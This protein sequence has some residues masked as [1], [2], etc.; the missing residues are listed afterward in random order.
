MGLR[1]PA[2]SSEAAAWRPL[3]GGVEV[4]LRPVTR[5]E[6]DLA[7][8]QAK[9]TI[10]DIAASAEALEEWGVARPAEDEELAELLGDERVAMGL[11]QYLIACYLARMVLKGWRGLTLEDG[12]PA[13][14]D[15]PT[16]KRAMAD[17][18]FSDAFYAVAC[19]AAF[20]LETEGNAF[21]AAPSG[22]GVA[23]GTIADDAPPSGTHAPQG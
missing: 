7:A 16:I 6:L 12:A 20:F 23:A 10:G 11:S 1:L 14:L 17:P 13:P 18:R 3:F 15:W 19:Q 8:A 2:P 21:A 9:R 22:S 4:Q 5:V